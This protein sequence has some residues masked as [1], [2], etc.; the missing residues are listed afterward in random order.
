MKLILYNIYK[1]VSSRNQKTS[2][3]L[4]FRYKDDVLS[5]NNPKFNDYIVIYPKELEIKDT[6][7]APNWVNYLDLCLEFD[8]D[9][10]L[11]TRLYDKCDD[12]YFPIINVPYLSRIFQNPL[13]MVFVFHSWYVMLGFVIEAGLFF[14]DTS[15]LLLGNYMVVIP[16]L[17][18]IWH[19]CAT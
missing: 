9:G 18:H 16:T 11:Y 19:F 1:R 4:T 17:S 13:H 12:F 2:F 10:K 6:T 8:Q 7:D 15:R 3:N 5:L 14:T